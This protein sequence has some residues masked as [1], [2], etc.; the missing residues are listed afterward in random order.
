MC[1]LFKKV[2]TFF[3]QYYQLIFAYALCIMRVIYFY[4][5][6]YFIFRTTVYMLYFCF[7]ALFMQSYMKGVL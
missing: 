2:H 3:V 7:Y 6:L 1:V 5:L 4:F